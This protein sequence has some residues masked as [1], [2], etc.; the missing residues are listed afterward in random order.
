VVELADIVRACGGSYRARFGST[1]LPSHL[2]ALWAIEHCRTATLGGHVHRCDRCQHEHFSY[3]SCLSRSCP[4]CQGQRTHE[5]VVDQQER[6]LDCDYFLCTF[7]LPH[8][9]RSVAKAHQKLVYGALLQAAAAALET[10]C[11]NPKYLGAQPGILAVLHTHGRDLSFHPHAHLVCTAG[12]LTAQGHWRFPTNARFLVPGWALSKIF[13]A[14]LRD[15]LQQA[16]LL[17]LVPGKVWDRRWV[18]HVQHAGRGQQV[19]DYLGRYLFRAPIA[20][21]HILAFDGSNVT[22]SFDSHRT[23]KREQQS[24]PAHEF[25]RRV[26]THTLPKGFHRVRYYGISSPGCHEKLKHARV[27]LERFAQAVS[28]ARPQRQALRRDERR[29]QP[30]SPNTHR[31]P[32]CRVGT[33]RIVAVL[34]RRPYPSANTRG[35]PS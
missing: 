28:L 12:G 7:T 15:A 34:S 33:M 19:V 21:S 24:V 10:L 35:P 11:L 13:R 20:N 14:K 27:L 6:L 8:V 1:L 2:R 17:S 9:L 4:K 25:L 30:P 16:D 31:C 18:V 29:C 22:F 23:G 3:H 32:A 26:L 5:W